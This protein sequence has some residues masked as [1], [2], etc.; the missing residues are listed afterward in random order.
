M[1]GSTLTLDQARQKLLSRIRC[2][3][4]H[5]II[6]LSEA[7]GRVLSDN[8][9]SDI[10]VP[11]KDNS[12]MD[13]IA[14]NCEDATELKTCLKISQRITA[15]TAPEK[16]ETGTA[17]RIFTGGEVPEG[18]N[19]V[20]IQENCE[21]SENDTTVLINKVPQARDNIRPM[22]Q[23]IQVGASIV[24]RG[25]KL[26]AVHLGLIASVGIDQVCVFK[27]IKVAIFST[28]DELVEPGNPL[29]P[30]Q[31][32]NSNRA[33]LIALCVQLGFDVTDLGVVKDDLEA[34]KQALIEAAA[35]ADIIITSGGVSVGD[36]DHLK[37]AI[38][39]LGQM[40]LWK[41]HMKP[42]KPVAYG[43]INCGDGASA[44]ILGLPGN[45]VSTYVVFLVIG[46]PILQAL[47]GQLSDTSNN[48]L[49]GFLVESGFDKKAQSREEFIRVKLNSKSAQIKVADVFNNQSSGVLTS[50]AWAD[51]LV[52]QYAGKPIVKGDSVTFIP[53]QNGLI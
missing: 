40:N 21:F 24:E 2:S 27:K 10:A 14:I 41:I 22:G 15:G 44:P 12:A 17:A 5:E 34:T 23:D 9:V 28:G 37:P 19:A 31:I 49:E 13:G 36:E 1:T 32:Y 53:L 45:P 43:E 6:Q 33:M 3:K 18:A 50:L 20:I 8:L 47:Q 30:G 48:L 46:V 7:L 52:R 29:K 16:L 35:S 39:Q 51:G 42:G 4:G 26:N 38:E 11:P 25:T